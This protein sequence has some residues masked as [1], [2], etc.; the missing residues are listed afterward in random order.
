MEF[1]AS[2]S[3]F[4]QKTSKMT[5]PRGVPRGKNPER[6]IHGISHRN[7]ERLRCHFPVLPEISRFSVFRDFAE[8]RAGLSVLNFTGKTVLSVFWNFKMIFDNHVEVKTGIHTLEDTLLQG[9]ISEL[10]IVHIALCRGSCLE[11][12]QCRWS[13]AGFWNRFMHR[14]GWVLTNLWCTLDHWVAVTLFPGANGELILYTYLVMLRVENFLL[15]AHQS[16]T[17]GREEARRICEA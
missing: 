1:K 10:R 9:R 3:W 8:N 12:R 11:T 2:F 14:G 7:P 5:N 15:R 13:L 16:P 4:Y 17:R 6:R